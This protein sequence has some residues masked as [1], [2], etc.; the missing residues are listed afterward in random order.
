MNFKIMLRLRFTG[1]YNPMNMWFLELQKQILTSIIILALFHSPGFSQKHSL[2]ENPLKGRAVF[3]QK[4]C[5]ICH[6]IN[7]GSDQIGPRLGTDNSHGRPLSLASTM[8]NHLPKMLLQINELGIQF[9]SFSEAE[10]S[11]LL[12]Y[13]FYLNYLGEPGNTYEGKNLI[14]EKGCSTCHSIGADGGSVGPP[15]DSF[16]KYNSPVFLAQALWNHGPAMDS[17][18]KKAS[19]SPPTFYKNDL[20][21]LNAYIKIA[22]QSNS[23]SEIFMSPGNPQKGGQLFKEK[24]CYSCHAIDGSG[25]DTGPDLAEKDWGYSA[26]EIAGILLNHSLSMYDYMETNDLDWPQF[27]DNEFA[28]IIAY[29]Y[30]LG[31]TDKLGDP[32]AG[33]L[34][35]ENKSCSLCHNLA[36]NGSKTSPDLTKTTKLISGIDM[37]LIMWNHAPIMEKKA[38]EK[39]LSWPTLDGKEMADLYAYILS[40]NQD[41]KN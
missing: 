3:E 33:E 2:P 23:S 1:Q 34:V 13:L 15:F 9:P 30:F 38:S 35:F 20:S 32:I 14:S 12:A 6:S 37:A 36:D 40:L 5:S 27:N 22:S 10:F 39:V 19:L 29:L 28:D 17:E 8:W 24:G 26:S 7:P 41:K 16:Q 11:E 4:G 25:G 18:L 31:F 21:D